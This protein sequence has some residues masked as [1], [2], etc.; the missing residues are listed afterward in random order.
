MR[1]FAV[2]LLLLLTAP[3][4]DSSRLEIGGGREMDRDDVFRV[5]CIHNWL[6]LRPRCFCVIL[7]TLHSSTLT[8]ALYLSPPLEKSSAINLITQSQ[9]PLDFC[10]HHYFQFLT[11]ILRHFTNK[12]LVVRFLSA[13]ALEINYFY[14][15]LF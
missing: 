3:Y 15:D 7:V 6:S 10:S 8:L 2:L 1:S 4:P 5:N 13:Q 12:T 11:V 14:D 9:F